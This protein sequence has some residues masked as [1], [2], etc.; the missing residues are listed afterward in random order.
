MRYKRRARVVVKSHPRPAQH[1]SSSLLFSF[2]ITNTDNPCAPSPPHV[3]NYNAVHPHPHCL[4][5]LTSTAAVTQR[6]NKVCGTSTPLCCQ[7]DVMGL[8]DT[9]CENR[10]FYCSTILHPLPCNGMIDRR[11]AG[12]KNTVL[13]NAIAPAPAE[14]AADLVNLCAAIGLMARYCEIPVL[15]QALG[16]ADP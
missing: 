3:N 9:N 7:T 8:G 16:C 6:Q 15:E 2:S 4:L 1:S 11:K 5:G 10:M 13:T 12:N 14:T